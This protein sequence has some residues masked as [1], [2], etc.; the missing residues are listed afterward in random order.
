[1]IELTREQKINYSESL[2]CL[3]EPLQ[4]VKA[5]CFGQITKGYVSLT[6]FLKDNTQRKLRLYVGG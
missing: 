2:R 4:D 5:F 6:V 1:M 3:V